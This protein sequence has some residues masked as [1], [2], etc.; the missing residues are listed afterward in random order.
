MNASATGR[1][2]VNARQPSAP[3]ELP[4]ARPRPATIVY[5]WVI[6]KTPKAKAKRDG[7]PHVRVECVWA[8][9]GGNGE[10]MCGSWPEGFRDETDAKRS[11]EE[12]TSA[13]FGRA[14]SEG[15]Q[16]PREKGPGPKPQVTADGTLLT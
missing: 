6:V 13:L 5:S 2:T 10:H 3:P 7:V 9:K 15:L 11:V 14:R 8:L 1:A 16:L 12:V 4:P